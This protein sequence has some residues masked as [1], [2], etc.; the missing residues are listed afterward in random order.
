MFDTNIWISFAIGKNIEKR[1][2]EF[3]VFKLSVLI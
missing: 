3:S 2:S 1:F